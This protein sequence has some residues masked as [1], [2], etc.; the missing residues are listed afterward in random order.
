MFHWTEKRIL[1][2][3]AL[4]YISFTLLNYLQ[5]QLKKNGL[6]QTENQIR[7]NLIKMQ[8]SLISQN[9]HEYY[10]RSKTEEGAK[11]IMKALSIR[12]LPDM[13]PGNSINQYL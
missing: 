12:E 5:L 11:Q 10:L 6:P 9:E 13:I 7:K 4:C 2:H 1:G 8:M 3:L